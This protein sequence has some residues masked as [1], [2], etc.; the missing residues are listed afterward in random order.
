M[1]PIH[2]FRTAPDNEE[3]PL[4]CKRQRSK[5]SVLMVRCTES[6]ADIDPIRETR[7]GRKRRNAVV[8]ISDL[9]LSHAEESLEQDESFRLGHVPHMVLCQYCVS[10]SPPA[11]VPRLRQAAWAIVEVRNRTC[12]S[13]NTTFAPPE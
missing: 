11:L 12:P 8:S 2:L 4:S 10:V 5:A 6:A 7:S 13:T 3:R 1:Q 9:L